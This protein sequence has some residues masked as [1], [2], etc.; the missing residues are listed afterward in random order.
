MDLPLSVRHNYDGQLETLEA[1]FPPGCYDGAGRFLQDLK[2]QYDTT[3]TIVQIFSGFA[4]MFFGIWMSYM[5]S[6]NY[7][8]IQRAHIADR[9]SFSCNVC[10]FVTT[11]SC[12]FNFFQVTEVDNIAL[13]DERAGFTL[14]LARPIEW[15]ITCPL[16]QYVL[17]VLGGPHIPEYRRI[18]MPLLSV[19]VLGCGTASLLTEKPEYLRYIW[20]I[21]GLHIAIVMFSL[22]RWQIVEH[23]GGQEDLWRPLNGSGSWFWKASVCL[24]VTWF[25]FPI[26][27]FLSPEGLGIINSVPVIQV[28]WGVLNIVSKFSFMALIQYIKTTETN[29]RDKRWEAGALE[30]GYGDRMG[31][32]MFNKEDEPEMKEIKSIDDGPPSPG[33]PPL[34][35]PPMNKR[36][37]VS[38]TAVARQNFFSVIVETM[39]SLG[40]EEH[41]QRFLKIL[42]DQGIDRPAKLKALTEQDCAAKGLPW[43]IVNS[44]QKT[45][46][47]MKTEEHEAAEM[48]AFLEASGA[49]KRGNPARIVPTF[50]P[51]DGLQNRKQGLQAPPGV[52][53]PIG[54]NIQDQLDSLANIFSD[55]L[56]MHEER[57]EARMDDLKAH[58]A[59]VMSNRSPSKA[60]SP[61]PSMKSGRGMEALGLD[62]QMKDMFQARE[63]MPSSMAQTMETLMTA[64]NRI[65]ER[66]NSGDSGRDAQQQSESEAEARRNVERMESAAS[67]VEMHVEHLRKQLGETR[68]TAHRTLQRKQTLSKELSEMEKTT[69]SVEDIMNAVKESI[70]V[71][72]RRMH[73]DAVSQIVQRMGQHQG[74]MDSG[75]RVV[76][77]DL[78]VTLLKEMQKSHGQQVDATRNLTNMVTEQFDANAAGFAVLRSH[79]DAGVD[80]VLGSFSSVTRSLQALLPPLSLDDEGGQGGLSPTRQ[81]SLTRPGSAGGSTGFRSPMKKN[82]R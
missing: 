37:S 68:E 40:L 63:E 58:I 2:G 31:E 25:P 26:W 47:N 62:V 6:R 3:T 57:N 30:S 5:N 28:G 38:D 12:F 23:S 10:L 36:M 34:K 49:N 77:N 79:M 27:F 44:V 42:A 64:V 41:S 61:S 72:T 53:E 8:T 4:F 71:E 22:N 35:A 43:S 74:M 51:Q 19:S 16:M 48:I 13:T 46:P 45:L 81:S 66:M 67:Q 9:M 7:W 18:L 52:M 21:V 73:E 14:D 69:R 56:R 33:S 78:T 20:Y 50:T 32:Y 70:L 29:R 39:L 55:S 11:F 24:I 54:E 60:P 82:G 1:S 80:R 17:V 15:I 65:E 75:P 59:S 76:D